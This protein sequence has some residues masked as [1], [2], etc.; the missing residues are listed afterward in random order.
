MFNKLWRLFKLEQET[1]IKDIFEGE[2]LNI[3]KDGD[4]YYISFPHVTINIPED[5]YIAFR[6]DI[7][8]LVDV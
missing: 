8:K 5:M 1:V 4:F 2:I 7:E 3:W 6:K